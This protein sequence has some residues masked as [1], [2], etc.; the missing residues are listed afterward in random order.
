MECFI[1][2]SFISALIVGGVIV[3][4]ALSF[5]VMASSIFMILMI[6]NGVF[7]S[8]VSTLFV[9][10]LYVPSLKTWVSEKYYSTNNYFYNI[11]NIN[12]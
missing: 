12:Y 5:L 4:I 11:Y 6:V 9:L 2:H 3:V 7:G 8:P 10:G 1:R